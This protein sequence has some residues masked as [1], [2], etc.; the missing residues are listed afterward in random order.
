MNLLIIDDEYYIVQG[1]VGM[2]DKEELGIDQIFTAYSAQ[3][4]LNMLRKEQVDLMLLDV[5]MPKETGLEL[6]E[7]LNKEGIQTTTIILSGHQR[8]DYAR[9][10]LHYHCFNYLL[11]P[12]GKQ[13]LNQELL[14]AISSLGSVQADPEPAPENDIQIDDT[15]FV[16]T[17]RS[18]ICDHL[19]DADLNRVKIA[20]A[21]HLNPDYLSFCFHKEFDTTLTAYIASKRMDQAKYLLK[22]TTLSIT[23]IAEQVGIPNTSYFYRQFKKATGKTPQQFRK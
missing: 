2:V 4:G 12:I 17:V 11:K 13:N 7:Q 23:E 21:I 19:S 15:G 6:L 22:N 8:F 9:E 1:L 18:Y 5:E 16:Q 3:Q 14:R 20:D 10:A